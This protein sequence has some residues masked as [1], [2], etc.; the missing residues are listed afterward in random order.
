M[1]KDTV[2]GDTASRSTDP[3]LVLPGATSNIS[4]PTAKISQQLAESQKRLATSGGNEK[5]QQRKLSLPGD[6]TTSQDGVSSGHHTSGRL[7]THKEK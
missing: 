5:Q 7:T 1:E 6:L 3:C 4:D 2:T